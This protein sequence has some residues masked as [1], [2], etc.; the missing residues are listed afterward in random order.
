MV[1]WLV[2]NGATIEPRA[3]LWLGGTCLCCWV[4]AGIEVS[5]HDPLWNYTDELSSHEL[6]P[7]LSLLILLEDLYV[8]PD[9]IGL[10]SEVIQRITFEE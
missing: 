4:R 7:W 8:E 9:A 3:S 1:S 5:S 10:H 2:T 6:F